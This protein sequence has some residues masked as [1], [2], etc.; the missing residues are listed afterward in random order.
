MV[1][2]KMILRN[3][4]LEV[5]SRVNW[6]SRPP[7]CTVW[8]YGSFFAWKNLLEKIK[9]YRFL[10]HLIGLSWSFS[11]SYFTYVS[12]LIMILSNKHIYITILL[13]LSS[14]GYPFANKK[15]SVWFLMVI[16]ILK[17]PKKIYGQITLLEKEMGWSVSLTMVLCFLLFKLLNK[18]SLMM[19]E[20]EMGT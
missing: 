16:L 10:P 9:T 7:L 6:S 20:K 2:A 15:E 8:P 19:H 11:S 18:K 3:G 5:L 1:F 17:M 4:F 12:A 13:T 14:K